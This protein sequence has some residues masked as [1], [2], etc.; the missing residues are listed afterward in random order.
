[1]SPPPEPPPTPRRGPRPRIDTRAVVR[2]AAELGIETFSVLAVAER[3]GV[4]DG[5]VYRYVPSR[6]RLRSLAAD[7][8]WSGLD[9]RSDATTLAAYLHDV[10]IRAAALAADH[11]G[12][13][14]YISFGPYEL[15]T[16]ASFERLMTEAAR[17]CRELGQGMAYVVV[18]RVLHVALGY[19][20]SG[21]EV[22]RAA[23]APVL[24]WHLSTLL[25]GMTA[26]IDRGDLPPDVDWP[27]VRDAVALSPLGSAAA[28][29]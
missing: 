25:D 27:A 2:A 11:P 8:V 5:A 10:A 14:G 24:G 18:S 20:A 17:R 12:L 6:E 26:A 9:T 15:A 23:N 29:V 3:L 16:I 21:D 1:M 13:A 22:L 28:T 4:S 19:A 7:H